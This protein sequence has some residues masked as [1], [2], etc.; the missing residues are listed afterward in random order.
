MAVHR[1]VQAVIIDLKLN[2]P[3]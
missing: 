2:L 1:R 3:R